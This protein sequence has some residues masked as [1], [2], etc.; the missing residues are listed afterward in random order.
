VVEGSLDLQALGLDV[1]AQA[2]EEMVPPGH[3]CP[4]RRL[5]QRVVLLELLVIDL[6]AT[7]SLIEGRDSVV[8]ERQVV[9]DRIANA[10][11]RVLVC[12]DLFD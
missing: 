12:E 6:G 11:R 1:S 5:L 4:S 10:R 2:G 7:P 9:G 8:V 3:R